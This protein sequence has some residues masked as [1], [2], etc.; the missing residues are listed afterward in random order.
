MLMTP[1]LIVSGAGR[2]LLT[3]DHKRSIIK[4]AQLQELVLHTIPLSALIQYNNTQ[5]I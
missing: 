4:L 1:F 3:P 5:E 2:F